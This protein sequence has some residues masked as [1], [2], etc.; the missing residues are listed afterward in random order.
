MTAGDGAVMVVRCDK[1]SG[2]DHPEN[3]LYYYRGKLYLPEL[4]FYVTHDL[5]HWAPRPLYNYDLGGP[6]IG[7]LM[8]T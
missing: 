7:E 4:H 6:E 5:N 8:L 2:L 3:G 1:W